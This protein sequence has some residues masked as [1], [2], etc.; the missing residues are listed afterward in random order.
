MLSAKDNVLSELSCALSTLCPLCT[1]LLCRSLCSLYSLHCLHTLCSLSVSSSSTTCPP[2]LAVFLFRF[3]LV[4]PCDLP[5]T[6]AINT[7]VSLSGM[8]AQFGA[9]VTLCRAGDNIVATSNLYGGTYN[10]F[11]VRLLLDWCAASCQMCS[12][13]GCCSLGDAWC[14]WMRHACERMRS[15]WRAMEMRGVAAYGGVA[16]VGG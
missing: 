1:L 9:L 2:S 10:Q 11:K 14:R 15:A 12:G 3:Y 8:S 5:F 16:M 6:S 4:P 13:D 7:T